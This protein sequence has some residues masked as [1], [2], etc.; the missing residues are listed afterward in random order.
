[1][2]IGTARE[3]AANAAQLNSGLQNCSLDNRWCSSPTC[4]ARSTSS[5]LYELSCAVNATGWTVTPFPYNKLRKLD[6]GCV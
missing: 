3:G 6:S 4:V 5:N 1:M 2:P